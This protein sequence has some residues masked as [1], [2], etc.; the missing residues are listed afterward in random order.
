MLRGYATYAQDVSSKSHLLA[1]SSKASEDATVAGSVLKKSA[2]KLPPTS[3]QATQQAKREQPGSLGKS[4]DRLE[5]SHNS[6]R[7]NRSGVQ[8]A[9]KT[10]TSQ[11]RKNSHERKL[12]KA[13]DCM[14]RH[15]HQLK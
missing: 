3:K 4:R 7:G 13:R 2:K 8:A 5:N 6:S 15:N 1:N 9:A 12:P 11:Q 10:P 14:I